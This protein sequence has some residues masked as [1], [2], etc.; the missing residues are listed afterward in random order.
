MELRRH[1]RPAD[2]AAHPYLYLPFEVPAGTTRIDIA[3][4]YPKASD[5]IIDLGCFDPRDTGFPAAQG[6]RGWSGGARDRAFVATDDAT[7]G[8]IPGPIPPGTWHVALGLYRVPPTGAEVTVRIGL[9]DAPRAVLPPPVAR[10]P[11]RPGA[12]W[13]RGDLHSHTHHS[14]ARGG[15]DLLHRAARQARLDFLA[16]SDH[17]TVAQRRETA[18]ATSPDLIFLRAMEITTAEGHANVFGLDDWIDFRLT[19]PE[20]AHVLAREV[21][22]KGGLLSVN[23]DKPPIPWTFDWPEAD[24]QEV[25]QQT[26]L[27]RN[28]VSLGR[29]QDRL[30]R[31]LRLSAIGGSDYHQPDALAPEGPFGLARPCTVLWL[32]ELSEAAVLDA[33]KAGRG[34]VTESPAGPQLEIA[35]GD[36]PMGAA[37]ARI[38]R[39]RVVVRG[40]GGDLLSL[41]DARGELLS[42]PVEGDDWQAEIPIAPRGFV[43]AEIVARD[44]RARLLAELSAALG[45]CPLPD[46]LTPGE[47]AGEKI[48]RAISNPV[49]LFPA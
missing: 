15:F 16:V 20:D 32:V 18:P 42:V 5:C 4:A 45:P 11:R 47:I 2:K 31:G 7:P 25:W 43:R 10:Q 9:D 35:A 44:S 27:A 13:Y 46:G 48:R 37:A 34:Y 6:F 36:V 17:N 14:D 39:L 28:G 21:H 40:A 26:W 30:A 41:W 23:H 24:C 49:Y 29:W 33:M 3:L 8:Y 22:A 12:G 1:I 38:D 19:A